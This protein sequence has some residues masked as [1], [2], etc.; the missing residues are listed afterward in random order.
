MIFESAA[1]FSNV[2]LTGN[3]NFSAHVSDDFDFFAKL[4][5]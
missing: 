2:N 1:S 5:A 3:W 4:F